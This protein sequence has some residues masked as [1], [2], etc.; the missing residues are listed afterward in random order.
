MSTTDPAKSASRLL[1]VAQFSKSTGFPK[2]TIYAW[3][4]HGVITAHQFPGTRAWRI[5]R[6]EL[7]RF[8]RLF[9][10]GKQEA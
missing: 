9:A 2:S 7:D 8:L 10:N 6:E 5:D 3:I 1:S 4:K